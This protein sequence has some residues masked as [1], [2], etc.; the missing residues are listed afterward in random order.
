MKYLDYFIMILVLIIIVSTAYIYN[1]ALDGNMITFIV[2]ALIM[3]ITFALL[4][5][6]YFINQINRCLQVVTSWSHYIKVVIMSVALIALPSICTIIAKIAGKNG[7]DQISNLIFTLRFWSTPLLILIV[8]IL[9]I[10]YIKWCEYSKK[11]H[12]PRD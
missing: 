3:S 12:F 7:Y 9:K 6:Y 11:R 10:T 5:A 8:T 2:T 4:T 1:V